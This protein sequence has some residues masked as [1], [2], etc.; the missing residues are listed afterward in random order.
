MD[1]VGKQVN[2]FEGA[3]Q[4]QKKILAFMMDLCRNE[5]FYAEIVAV[6]RRYGVPDAGMA[7]DPNVG[8]ITKWPFE[9]V[10]GGADNLKEDINSLQKRYFLRPLSLFPEILY[11]LIA[12]DLIYI[13][14][15][16]DLVLSSEAERF[17][18]FGKTD[19]GKVNLANEYPVTLRIS[20]HASQRDVIDYVKKHFSKS[21]E[22]KLKRHRDY[23]EELGK[24]RLKKD[25]EI[26]DSIYEHKDKTA[27]ELMGIIAT[28]HGEVY[29]PAAIAKKR[30][31]EMKRRSSDK[32]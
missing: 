31:L 28:K 7:I 11:V 14:E 22:L 15:Y 19:G 29:D 13:P 2:Q 25:Q 24:P 10:K 3:T 21:I 6:R 12:Y 1:C 27:S 26:L 4:G 23:R 16:V 5:Q 32:K 20:K 30:S 9:E 8:V 17:S 18:L